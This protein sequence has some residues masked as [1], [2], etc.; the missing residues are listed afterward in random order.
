VHSIEKQLFVQGLLDRLDESR[1]L[2]LQPNDFHRQWHRDGDIESA[3]LNFIPL[4]IINQLIL[5]I[6][7]K[8]ISHVTIG[9]GFKTQKIRVSQ[10]E[11]VIL[12]IY[13]IAKN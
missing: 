7:F 3:P 10:Q 1:L 4:Q 8:H 2:G 13:S 12:I 5:T 6:T 11:V 9:L